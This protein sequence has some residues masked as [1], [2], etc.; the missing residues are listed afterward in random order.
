MVVRVCLRWLRLR[1][2]SMRG[3]SEI[4]FSEILITISCQSSVLPVMS[5]KSGA[6][7]IVSLFVILN[8]SFP[9]RVEKLSRDSQRQMRDVFVVAGGINRAK[10]RMFSNMKM[11]VTD[12]EWSIASRQ[13][14]NWRFLA[15]KPD[16]EPLLAGRRL[17][18]T[19]PQ[20]FYHARSSSWLMA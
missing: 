9:V 13:S 8:F 1:L 7:P 6:R 20:V 15:T 14:D 11:G 3:D 5:A 17:C 2:R 10:S 18:K 19:S 16:E 12:C 4:P